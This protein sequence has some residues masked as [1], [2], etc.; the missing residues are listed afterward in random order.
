MP[1]YAAGDRVSSHR[2]AGFGKDIGPGGGENEGT[3]DVVLAM[4]GV[5]L[6]ETFLRSEVGGQHAEQKGA[7]PGLTLR[8][9]LRIQGAGKE[10]RA[11]EPPYR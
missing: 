6:V 1:G 9:R 3:H 10:A 2:H 7:P 4:Y 11:W 5:V 8:Q